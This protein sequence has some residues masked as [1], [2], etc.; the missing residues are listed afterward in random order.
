MW[1][2]SWVDWYIEK[3]SNEYEIIPGEAIVFQVRGNGVLVKTDEFVIVR[4][5]INR[6]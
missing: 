5:G 1:C 4:F 3:N 6:T 2:E